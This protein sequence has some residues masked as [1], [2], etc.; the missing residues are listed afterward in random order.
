LFPPGVAVASLRGQGSPQILTPDELRSVSHCASKR[1]QDFAAGRACARRALLELGISGFS[2]LSGAG[3][4]PLWPA[5]YVG[6]LTHTM[7]FSA[8][9]VGLKSDLPSVGIDCEVMAAVNEDVWPSICT[10]IE[11]ERLKRLEPAQRPAHAALI[12]AA[13]EAFYKFQ[14]PLTRAWVGFEDVVI[15]PGPLLSGSG[16]F[17]VFPQKGLPLGAESVRA[18]RGRFL[19][20]EGWVVTGVTA[21][22]GWTALP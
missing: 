5:G 7:G 2:L 9:V 1:I 22:A 20:L 16:S 11:L 8:A 3:R 12:F 21:P 14:Y 17:E 13:K 6:S 18:L 4:V 10:P 19:L 15:Q